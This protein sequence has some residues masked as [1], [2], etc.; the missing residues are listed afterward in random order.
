MDRAEVRGRGEGRKTLQRR[1][2]EAGGRT[3]QR[4]RGGER[5]ERCRRGGVTGRLGLADICGIV[6]TG[7]LLKGDYVVREEELFFGLEEKIKTR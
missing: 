2:D 1:E 7:A 4:E 5:G 6:R 3:L